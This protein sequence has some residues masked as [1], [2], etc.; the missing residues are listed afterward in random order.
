L[1]FDGTLQKGGQ[2]FGLGGRTLWV[3]ISTPENL[4]IRV[5]GRTIHLPG[6]APR[7]LTITPSGWHSAS[8]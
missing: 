8:S 7:V 5:R 2:P 3:Q 6:L 4:L 1:A